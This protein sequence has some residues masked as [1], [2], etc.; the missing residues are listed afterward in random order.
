MMAE[1][2]YTGP[3][4]P[5]PAEIPPRERDDAMGAYLMMFASL[6]VGLPLP[7][8]GVVASIVYFAINAKRSRFVAFHSLQSLLAHI[9]VALLNGGIVVWLIVALVSERGLHAAFWVALALVL[10][11]NLA[12]LILSVIALRR[13]ARGLFWYLPLIGGLAFSRYYGP[14]ARER[15]EGRHDQPEMNKPPKGFSGGSRA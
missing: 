11:L 4:L 15:W 12:Y 7:F 13:A 9:P 5:A 3:E 1:G 8:I 2:D 14:G 10:A 6:A